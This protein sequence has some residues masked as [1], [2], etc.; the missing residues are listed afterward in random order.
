MDS[1][2]ELRM[3]F[4]DRDLVDFVLRLPPR[5]RASPWPGHANTKQI[6]RHWGRTHLPAAVL[7]RKKRT[8]NF[9]N[10]RFLLEH[11]GDRL[12]DMITG[13]GALR[14]R[15]PGLASLLS[16][17]PDTIRGPSEGTLWALLS[18]AVWARNVELN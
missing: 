14:E 9:G 10:I 8:F 17:P 12:R 15:L 7:T 2:A 16:R 1:S 5:F 11:G 13:V 3:P 4:L 6:L 18:L